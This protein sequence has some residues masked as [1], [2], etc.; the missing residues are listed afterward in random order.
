MKRNATAIGMLVILA[1][2]GGGGGAGAGSGIDPRLA[3]LDTYEAQKLRVL[4]NPAMGVASM[5][6]T[7]L[8]NVP[9]SGS[10][11]FTGSATVR[12][13]NGASPLVMFGD[14]ELTLGFDTQGGTGTLDNFFGNDANGAVVDYTGTIGLTADIAQ[15]ALTLDYAGTLSGP[16]DSL[17][18]AGQMEG[19]FLGNPLG[20]IAAADLEASVTHNGT[21]R[22]ATLVVIGEVSASP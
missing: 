17:I 21:S 2:C 16:G 19:A 5:P 3:R 7:E 22:D 13:E 12:V 9:T 11:V 14:A 4:G 6:L 15:T 20:A 18:F 10:T 1:G 8:G